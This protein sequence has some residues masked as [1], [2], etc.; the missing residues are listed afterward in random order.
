MSQLGTYFSYLLWISIL[1]VVV[2]IILLVVGSLYFKWYFNWELKNRRGLK[3]YGRPFRT[4]RSFKRKIKTHS[5]FLKPVIFLET[6]LRK[7]LGVQDI[8][9]IIFQDVQGPS[10]SCTQESFEQAAAYQPSLN[11]I[12]IVTQMKCGTTWMQQVVFQILTRGQGTFSDHEYVH[13]S[14]ISPWIEAIDGVSITDAPLIGIPGRKILK[15]HLPTNL[16]PYNQKAKYIYVVRHP[17]SCFGSI[18]DYFKLTA[19]P[20]S[21]SEPQVLQW[22]CSDHMW[23]QPWPDHVGNWWELSEMKNNVFFVSFEQMKKDPISVIKM[24]STFFGQDLDLREI[25]QHFK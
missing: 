13:L 20:F 11:D 7:K 15:T 16:C 22:F 25:G 5:F 17:V 14:A 4:R 24:V 6:K 9:S 12:F 19:G 2:I 23:W 8:A 1:F 21:P 10:F 18:M 3:Y